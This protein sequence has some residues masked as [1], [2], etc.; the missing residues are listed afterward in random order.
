MVGH[1]GAEYATGNCEQ[2]AEFFP[3]S[4]HLPG[5]RLSAASLSGSWHQL[6]TGQ[7]AHASEALATTTFILQG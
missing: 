3:H 2:R 1:D 4:S 5:L 7:P 6:G